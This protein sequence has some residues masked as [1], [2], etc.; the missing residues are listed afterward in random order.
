[1]AMS[2]EDNELL[3][4]TGAGTLM[5]DLFRRFWL[6]ALLPDELPG[7]DCPPVRRPAHGRTPDRLPRQHR[8]HRPDRRV[9]RPSR[10]VAVVR[11]QR[12]MR[13]ALRLSRLEIRRDRAMRRPPLRAEEA[14]GMRQRIRLKAYPC[15]EH[16]GADLG[17]YGPAGA[18]A[19]AAGARMDA[20]CRRSGATSRSACRTATTCRRWKAASI[21]AT[22]PSCTAADSTRDPMFRGAKGND[23]TEQRPQAVFRGRRIRWRAVDRRAA[24]R[25]RT[26]A[27]TGAS[28]RGSCRSTRSSRRAPAIP[29]GGHAWVPIDDDALLGVEPQ[30]PAAPG[31]FA[32]RPARGDGGRARHPFARH[33]PAPSSRSPTSRTTI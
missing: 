3:T 14:T 13:P 27:I 33:I 4:R 8:P 26:T 29:I 9:L 15:V 5:G 6:P 7:P 23:Y 1:M 20:W 2:K 22:C 12:G 11:A 10:R 19:R 31:R 17:L 28:R 18:E 16:G 32:A 25:R 30:L 24:Q 21:R